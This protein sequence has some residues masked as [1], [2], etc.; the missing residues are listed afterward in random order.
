MR[1]VWIFLLGVI[2]L[3]GCYGRIGGCGCGCD[4]GCYSCCCK[5]D[6]KQK[7]KHV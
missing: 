4:Y 5:V 3:S 6:K 2:F 1:K 7:D